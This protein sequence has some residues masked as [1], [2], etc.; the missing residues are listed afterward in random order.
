MTRTIP[1]DGGGDRDAAVRAGD[2]SGTQ[3]PLDEEDEVDK[4]F[5]GANPN[6]DGTNCP[7]A[8]RLEALARGPGSQ[9]D[10]ILDHV[11]RCSPC[12]R[13]MRGLRSRA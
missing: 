2:E 5:A 1:T 13:H 6:E 11:E 4:L 7:S 3:S 8:S 9:D 12:Y 10:P